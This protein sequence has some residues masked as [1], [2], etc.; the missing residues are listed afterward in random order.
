MSKNIIIRLKLS[1]TL[2]L[3]E[4]TNKTTYTQVLEERVQHVDTTLLTPEEYYQ[5]TGREVQ[6]KP[7]GEEAGQVVF[8][9]YPVSAVNYVST[10]S[11]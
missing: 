11:T 8:Q 6:P 3:C 9:Y 2:V 1:H 7:V 4:V 10:L 5:P